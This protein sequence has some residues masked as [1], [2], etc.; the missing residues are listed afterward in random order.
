[1][2]LLCLFVFV[3]APAMQRIAL[4]GS[5]ADHIDESGIE[6]SALYY[7]GV[8]ETATAE[9]YLH[10]ARTFDPARAGS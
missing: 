3:I 8:E 4:I 6:A 2:L 5:I 1:M 9:M 10:N 7:T